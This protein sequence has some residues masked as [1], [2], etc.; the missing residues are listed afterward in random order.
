MM[1][2]AEVYRQEQEEECV[3]T[4]VDVLQHEE[5]GHSRASVFDLRCLDVIKCHAATVMKTTA[6]LIYSRAGKS[7]NVSKISPRLHPTL[8][9]SA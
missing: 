9:P 7:R 4:A 2:G 5:H 8:E 3:T 1:V 6:G